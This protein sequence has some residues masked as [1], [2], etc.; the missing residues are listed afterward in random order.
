MTNN[1]KSSLIDTLILACMIALLIIGAHQVYVIRQEE[2][3]RNAFF[4]SYYI[5]M[6]IVILMAVQQMRKN[7]K[8]K[9]QAI[10]GKENLSD[11]GQKKSGKSGVK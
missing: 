9:D 10:S 7:K 11:N 3:F 4:K 5:F 1:N 8:L 6:L 2:G